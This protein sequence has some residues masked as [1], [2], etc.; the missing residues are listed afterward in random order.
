MQ[1]TIISNKQ[2]AF[3]VKRPPD[4]R[5]LKDTLGFLTSLQNAKEQQIDGSLSKK[6][7]QLP[8]KG[9][10]IGSFTHTITNHKI[11][12]DVHHQK[13]PK[14]ATMKRIPFPNVEPQLLSN[15]DRKAW[16]IFQ[17]AIEATPLFTEGLLN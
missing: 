8:G 10:H 15:L 14:G 1:L 17:K 4:A 2:E 5:F 16:K 7:Q 12:V 9:S 11:S 6:L 3:L 13:M